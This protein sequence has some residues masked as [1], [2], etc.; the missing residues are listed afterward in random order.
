MTALSNSTLPN[1]GALTSVIQTLA[2]LTKP[3][4]DFSILAG[5]LQASK[6]ILEDVVSYND[7]FNPAGESDE[8]NIEVIRVRLSDVRA[9]VPP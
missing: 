4:D 1:P 6:D 5:N 8:R 2:D 3:K 7:K 9:A